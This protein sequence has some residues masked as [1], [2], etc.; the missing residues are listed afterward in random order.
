MCPQGVLRHELPR[1]LACKAGFDTACDVDLCQ[2]LAFMRQ[3]RVEFPGFTG[4]VGMFGV[5]LGANRD[6]FPGGHGHRAGR[7]PGDACDQRIMRRGRGR[8]DPHHKAGGRDDPVVCARDRGAEPSYACD[9][10]ALWMVM[11]HRPV[12]HLSGS[13]AQQTAFGKM[14]KQRASEAAEH[15]FLQARMG[16]AAS[17]HKLGSMLLRSQQQFG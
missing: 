8:G 1:D 13:V 10:M 17:H 14:A 2:F 12:L 4:Q 3:I 7:Q 5:G 15:P 9:Q 16:V 11:S 6:V